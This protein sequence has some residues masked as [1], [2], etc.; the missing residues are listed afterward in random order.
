MSAS[1]SGTGK[2]R[3]LIVEDENEN[4]RKLRDHLEEQGFHVEKRIDTES[5]LRH[6]LEAAKAGKKWYEFVMID[7]D[8][9]Y[10]AEPD[11]GIDIYHRVLHEFPEETYIIYSHQDLDEF[12]SRI[13]QLMYRNVELVLLDEVLGRMNIRFHL[14]R[15]VQRVPANRVFIIHGR[16]HDKLVRMKRLLHH[17]FGLAVIEWEDARTNAQSLRNYIFDIVLSGIEMSHLTVALFTDDEIVELRREFR[18]T[19]DID[20]TLTREKRRQARPNVYIEAGYA[21]GVRPKRTIFV[22]WPDRKK[23]FASPSDFQGIHA[24]RFEDTP[25]GREALRKR[26]EDARCTLA[27]ARNWRTMRL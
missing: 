12:R 25:E 4:Y 9:S 19:D 13:N 27:P 10:S 1:T 20:A 16:N 8:L 15:L 2:G 6:Y 3:V 26:L 7:I 5:E 14:T 18:T 11:N 22:E 23:L 21:I 17:G 24:L